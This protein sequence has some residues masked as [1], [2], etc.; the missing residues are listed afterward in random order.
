MTEKLKT[1]DIPVEESC[2]VIS[3][4]CLSALKQ[5]PSE[6]VHCCVTSPPY[7]GLRD[8]GTE[9]QIWGGDDACPHEW[10]DVSQDEV[11]SSY[12]S[13]CGAWKGHLGLEPSPQLF[14]KNLVLI[15]NEVRRVLR[16]DGLLFL[17]IGDSYAGSGK[18]ARNKRPGPKQASNIGS[19][20]GQVG[21]LREGFK[22]KELMMMPARVAIALSESGW[23][24]RSALPWVKRSAM[25]ES[26]NDRPANALEYVYMFSKEPK[27]YFDMVA[28]RKQTSNAS[29]PDPETRRIEEQTPT[30]MAINII[31]PKAASSPLLKNA[32]TVRYRKTA[33]A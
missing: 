22:R 23:Y 10:P 3:G 19:I 32:V 33:T 9:P 29:I 18:A 31:A 21:E 28:I 2:C 12:C 15:F 7:F 11:I 14:I 8:Y 6:S 26:I 20:T 24:L 5:M 17:N 13:K 27:Y 30:R 16:K 1:E 25:P 4:D